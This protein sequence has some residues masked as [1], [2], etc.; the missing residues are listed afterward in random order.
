VRSTCR[1]R[2][3]V[4]FVPQHRHDAPPLSFITRIPPTSPTPYLTAGRE[5]LR[6]PSQGQQ[7]VRPDG[8]SHH[9]GC[10][11][12]KTAPATTATPSSPSSSPAPP[13]L[14][15]PRRRSLHQHVQHGLLHVEEQHPRDAHSAKRRRLLLV[16]RTGL[17]WVRVGFLL[18]REPFRVALRPFL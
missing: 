9:P 17:L 2:K 16:L 11:G 1:R 4:C 6:A 7:R 10:G 14:G 12:R 13:S 5:R 3:R 15:V 8:L 18:G